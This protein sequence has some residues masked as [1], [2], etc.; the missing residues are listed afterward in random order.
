[1]D[2]PIRKVVVGPDYK[3][4]MHFTVGQSVLRDDN[5]NF[6]HKILKID[7]SESSFE[8]WIENETKEVFLWKEFKD[9]PVFIEY[10]IDY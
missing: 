5:R 4:G 3:N 7:R 9:T 1:M 8:V 10:S 6:T 2:Y